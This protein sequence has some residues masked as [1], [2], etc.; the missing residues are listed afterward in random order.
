MRTNGMT[1]EKMPLF[2]WAIFITAFLLLFSLPV[3]AA[4]VTMLLLDRQFNTS[5][6][7]VSGGGDPV[8]YEHLFYQKLMIYLIQGQILYNDNING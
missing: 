5:F 8:L 2:G 1:M 6:F 4:G 3:L 7:E